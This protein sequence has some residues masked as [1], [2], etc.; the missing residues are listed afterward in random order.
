MTMLASPNFLFIAESTF[1]NR[2]LYGYTYFHY[3]RVNASEWYYQET[4]HAWGLLKEGHIIFIT[5]IIV[6]SQVNSRGGTQL[7][8]STENR[9]KNLLSMAPP[10][11]TRP[12]FPLSQSLPSR[13]VHKPLILPLFRECKSLKELAPKLSAIYALLGKECSYFDFLSHLSYY[14]SPTK[15]K[16][17]NQ[18]K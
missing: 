13:N 12:S 8:P 18:W 17:D 10:I 1:V 2:S 16:T 11:R 14:I 6:S 5:S 7:H 3:S 9:I 15:I 4:V